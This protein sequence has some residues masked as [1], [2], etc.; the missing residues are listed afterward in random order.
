MTTLFSA[1]LLGGIIGG[2]HAQSRVEDAKKKP[3]IIRNLSYSIFPDLTGVYP[4][5]NFI[6]I[7]ST[8]KN[9]DNSSPKM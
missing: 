2:L 9:S 5:S 8:P 6:K 7:S 1:I 3:K 4:A